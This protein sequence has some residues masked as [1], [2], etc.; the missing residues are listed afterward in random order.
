ME[1]KR[2]IRVGKSLPALVLSKCN[3]SDNNN[4]F[5]EPIVLHEIMFTFVFAASTSEITSPL[6]TVL[7]LLG[8]AIIFLVL[9]YNERKKSM[10]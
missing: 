2:I 9:V 7:D 8:L 6:S 1:K 10:K 4:K 3:N 5:I